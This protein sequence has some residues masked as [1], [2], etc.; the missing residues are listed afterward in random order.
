MIKWDLSQ[1]WQDVS[2]SPSQ[3][4]WYTSIINW[5][6]KNMIIS[7]NAEKAFDKIQHPFVIKTLQKVGREWTYFNII[8]AIYNKPRANIILNC[9]KMKAF[10]LRS[11]KRQGCPLSWLLFNIGLEVLAMAFREEKEM[12]ENWK[13][14]NKTVTADD[15][16]L[17]TENPKDATRKLRG[18]ISVFGKVAWH[19]IIHR[20]LLHSY[21]LTTK[22]QK[23]KLK[24]QPIYH[25]IKKNKIP[26]N[27]P[28]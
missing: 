5:R 3:S 2:V 8:K 18:L 16:I 21:S 20:N 9:E 14:R 11:G 13:R 24:K 4:V 23:E 27:K 26:R 17:Y 7:I 25:L 6:L 22:N 10:P 15:M 28:T 19:K 12:N 1:G